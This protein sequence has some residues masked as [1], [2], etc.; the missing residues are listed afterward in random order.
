LFCTTRRRN[1]RE[2][3]ERTEKIHSAAGR[4][5]SL[6]NDDNRVPYSLVNL[7]KIVGIIHGVLKIGISVRTKSSQWGEAFEVPLFHFHLK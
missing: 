5:F 6:L 4:K 3:E 2:Q 1:I 7:G